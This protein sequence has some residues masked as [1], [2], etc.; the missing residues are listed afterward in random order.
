MHSFTMQPDHCVSLLFSVMMHKVDRL[1]TQIAFLS[2]L[3]ALK[4][5]LLIHLHPHT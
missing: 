4:K 2:K 3:G 5:H 1:F